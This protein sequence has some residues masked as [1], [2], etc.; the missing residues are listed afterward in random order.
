MEAWQKQHSKHIPQH[1]TA[2]LANR[3]RPIVN[4]DA[5]ANDQYR[6]QRVLGGEDIISLF[7]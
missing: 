2:V 1:D 4:I 6:Q 5:L 7:I 3:G